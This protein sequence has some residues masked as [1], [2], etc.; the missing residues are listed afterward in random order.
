MSYWMTTVR[1]WN[2]LPEEVVNAK[3][4]IDFEIGLDKHWENQALLYDNF[5]A[6][7]KSKTRGNNNITSW[8]KG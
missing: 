3:E 1:L 6:E 2:S 7:I 8:A 5:L 4:V